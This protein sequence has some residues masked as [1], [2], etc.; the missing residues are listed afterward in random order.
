M[1]TF[2]GG[3]IIKLFGTSGIRGK[4]NHNLFPSFAYNIGKIIAIMFQK[5]NMR[6]VVGIDN[7]PSSKILEKALVCGL[8]S[9]GAD[10]FLIGEVVTPCVSFAVGEIKADVGVMITGSHKKAGHNGFKI[11]NG[12]GYKITDEEESFIENAMEN[13]EDILELCENEIGNCYERYDIKDL[14]LNYISKCAESTVQNINVLVDTAG[15]NSFYFLDKIK[16]KIN[17]NIDFVDNENLNQYGTNN[18]EKLQKNITQKQY[19]FGVAFD[20][21]GDRILFVDNK[22]NLINNDYIAN[23]LM[24]F[25]KYKNLSLNLF[26]NTALI[27]FLEKNQTNCHLSKVGE[28]YITETM[29]YKNCEL[30]YEKVGHYIFNDII[31]TSD[32]LLTFIKLLNIYSLNKNLFAECKQF[33]FYPSLYA[34]FE[35]KNILEISKNQE[36]KQIIELCESLALENSKIIVRPSNVEDEIRVYV[37]TTSQKLTTEIFEKITNKLK[38]LLQK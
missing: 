30:G 23:L 36:L 1:N 12:N 9:L 2:L 4:Y 16:E 15:G 11:F 33:E 17:L 20:G 38:T 28:K 3:E 6:V 32:G 31:N 13:C 10:A 8:N 25:Y 29:L 35:C 14:Y 5:K 21:D 34:R 22:G 19:D 27:E 37:E 26:S 24:R 7:R 18:L